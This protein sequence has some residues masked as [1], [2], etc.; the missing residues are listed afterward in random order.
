MRN[1]WA[2][3]S[4]QEYV[5]SDDRP[6]VDAWNDGLSDESL[7]L[8][9]DVVPEPF[10]GPRDAPVVVLGRNPGWREGLPGDCAYD[11]VVRGNLGDDPTR[12]V[13]PGFLKRFEESRATGGCGA[14]RA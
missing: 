12:H 7:R 14:G 13:H 9:T 11:D 6:Y 5:L 1:P 3:L 2:R 4:S 8:R 10:V